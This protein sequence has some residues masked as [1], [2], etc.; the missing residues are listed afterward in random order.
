MARVSRRRLARTVVGLLNQQPGQ[1]QQIMKTLAAYLVANKLHKQWDL[2]MLDIAK[3]LAISEGHVYAEVDS[4]FAIDTN[5]RKE[6]QAYIKQASGA[7]TVELNERVDEGLLA[8]MV[9]RTA[10]QQCD[11]SARTKLNRLSSLH[12]NTPNEA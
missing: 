8:G 12:I 1:Q 7:T 4:A 10:D 5:A 6:L 3:E 2:V 11:T 9:I